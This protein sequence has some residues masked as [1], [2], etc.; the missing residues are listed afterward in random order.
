MTS[1]FEQSLLL[2][3]DATAMMIVEDRKINI[4]DLWQ[5]HANLE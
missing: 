3:G 1:L 4:A 2:F 5:Y